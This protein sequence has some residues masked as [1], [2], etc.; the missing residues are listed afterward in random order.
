MLRY[1]YNI[2]VS[3]FEANTNIAR[4]DHITIK[5]TIAN[6]WLAGFLRLLS[7]SMIRSPIPLKCLQIVLQMKSDI[8]KRTM[9]V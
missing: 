7:F 3:T 2:S 4:I 9:P 1:V 6:P 5:T 8:N